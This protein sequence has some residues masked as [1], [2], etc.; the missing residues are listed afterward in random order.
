MKGN[1]DTDETPVMLSTSAYDGDTKMFVIKFPL[2]SLG[3]HIHFHETFFAVE[4]LYHDFQAIKNKAS[5]ASDA[6]F[7]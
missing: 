1:A 4:F 3:E 5:K 6:L 7:C 2:S